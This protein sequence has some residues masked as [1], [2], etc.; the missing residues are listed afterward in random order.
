[1][2]ELLQGAEELRTIS[3]A[4]DKRKAISCASFSFNGEIVTVAAIRPSGEIELEDG[5]VL[6]A[7]YRQ[8]VHG[9]AVTSYSSQGKT[10]DHVVFA[11][12]AVKAATDAQQW[13]VTISRG[14]KSVQIFT[15]DKSQLRESVCRSGDRPLAL[16][17]QPK[18]RSRKIR[19]PILRGMRRGRAF[20]KA[21][22]QLL[23]RKFRPGQRVKQGV[24]V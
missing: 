3:K 24:T 4:I 20:A 17:L 19:L 10:V 18:V 1:M 23:A 6:P 9:Y 13:Y 16:D 12:S 8:F 15:M 5:R 7:Y 22:C 21:V 11:D 14:R 2:I